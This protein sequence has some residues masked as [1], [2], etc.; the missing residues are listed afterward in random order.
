MAKIGPEI[1]RCTETN[2][3]TDDQI[4]NLKLFEELDVE[5]AYTELDIRLNE[6]ETAENL[7]QQSLDYETTVGACMQVEGCIGM[8]VWDF[9]DPVCYASVIRSM[10][11]GEI[12]IG[13]RC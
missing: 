11:T 1:M 2:D 12:L 10:K 6:P 13:K 4:T 9:Y 7:A 8:T 3:K 5:L